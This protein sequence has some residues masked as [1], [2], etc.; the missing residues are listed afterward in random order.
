[1]AWLFAR[2][3]T[4]RKGMS[5]TQRGQH[6]TY[7]DVVSRERRIVRVTSDPTN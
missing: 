3:A 4:K 1:M 7:M 5:V 6:V 2:N